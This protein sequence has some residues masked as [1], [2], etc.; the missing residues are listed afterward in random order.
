MFRLWGKIFKDNR[1]LQDSVI[2]DDSVDTACYQ[3]K[4]QYGYPIS[5][6]DH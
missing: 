2:E 1:M 6:F 4:E 5:F 3:G